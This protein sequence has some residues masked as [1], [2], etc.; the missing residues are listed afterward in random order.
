MKSADAKEVYRK[1][2]VAKW[3]DLRFP[4]PATDISGNWCT[5]TSANRV[6]AASTNSG[7]SVSA[8][9]CSFPDGVPFVCPTQPD[10]LLPVW[11]SPPGQANLFSQRNCLEQRWTGSTRNTAG[12]RAKHNSYLTS[13]L[14]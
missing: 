4:S 14:D 8:P 10:C 13:Q 5:A 2:G 12:G 9:A 6:K 1:S 11:I 3:R 7:R